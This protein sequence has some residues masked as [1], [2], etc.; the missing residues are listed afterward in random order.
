MDRSEE[1]NAK[2]ERLVEMLRANQLGGVLI[3]SQHN[4]SWLTA[5]GSNGIDLSRDAGAGALL[6]RADGKRYLLASRNEMSRLLTEEIPEA[7]FEPVEFS[8]E[9]EKASSIFVVERAQRLLTANR[10]LGSDLYIS[11]DAKLIE[12]NIARCRYQLTASEIERLRSLASDASGAIG[13]LARETQAGE[14]EREIAR[15]VTNAL[16]AYKIRSVVTLVAA[17]DRISMYRHPVPSDLCW[18]KTLMIVV[19][20]RRGGLIA[21]LTRIVCHGPVP[22]DLR[23]R[24]HAAAEVNAKLYAATRPG[25][26]GA[27]LFRVAAD[28]YATAGFEHEEEFHHQGGATG[29]RTRDWVAHPASNERVQENQA[30]AWNPTITGTKMEETCIAFA[31]DVQVVTATPGWPQIATQVGGREYLS[32]DILSL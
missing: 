8:W 18:Q 12:S 31:T 6:V 13:K 1:I 32:P 22:E 26:S 30:F 29:Y 4:F 24:T 9:E 3:S 15:R 5:G 16:A 19:C 28:A 20:A 2:T 25:V 17:D 10:P 27:D 7:G 14:S 11:N 21:S 23:R